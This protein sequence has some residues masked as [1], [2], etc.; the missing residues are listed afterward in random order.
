VT[1]PDE[2]RRL[3]REA[4]D[5]VIR[6]A[7]VERIA[8]PDAL[9]RRLAGP[10]IARRASPATRCAAMDGIAVRAAD[11]AGA[12]VVLAPGTFAPVD[13]G[14]PVASRWDAV[15]VRERVVIRTDGSAEV[16]VAVEVGEDIRPVGEDIAAG[17]ELLPAGT[18]IGPI[19]IA[20]AVA[21]GADVVDVDRPPRVAIVPTGD[22]IVAA[23][24][25]AGAASVIDSNSPMLAA[26]VRLARAEPVAH[27]IVPDAPERLADAIRDAAACELILVVAGSSAGGRDHTAA[28]IAG[29]GTLLVRGVRMRPGHPVLLGVAYG[30]PVIGLPG[31]PIA[32]AAA[33]HVFAA[34]LIARL[35]GVAV[36]VVDAPLADRVGARPVTRVVPVRL[37]GG[38]AHPLPGKAGAIRS[39]LG[40][41]GMIEVAPGRDL[42]AG[43]RVSVQPFQHP[44]G[45]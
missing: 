9:H 44:V 39:A 27:P 5:G 43:D 4:C 33:F 18:R 21:A 22:E 16:R 35:R 37:A 29:A 19:E 38:L 11:T 26:L 25:A 13:T 45:E 40:A 34:P 42:A 1:S 23:E 32:A 15:V 7:P 8:P 3:W 20:A 6:P 28:V 24:A 36:P 30:T 10:V 31:Y 12:P 17:Q 14:A 2:A 41:D